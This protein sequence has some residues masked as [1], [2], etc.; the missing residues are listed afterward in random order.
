VSQTQVSSQIGDRF[1]QLNHLGRTES[2][3][4]PLR[5]RQLWRESAGFALK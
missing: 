1:C 4:E 2:A 5:R 3:R